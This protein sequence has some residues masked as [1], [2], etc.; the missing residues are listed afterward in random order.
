MGFA[1]TL[2]QHKGIF[3]LECQLLAKQ[4]ACVESKR[5]VNGNCRRSSSWRPTPLTPITHRLST[6]LRRHEAPEA[7][8]TLLGPREG[9]ADGSV[10]QLGLDTVDQPPQRDVDPARHLLP[11][12]VPDVVRG[13]GDDVVRQLDGLRNVQ[14]DGEEAHQR[15]HVLISD[16][17]AVFGVAECEG[18]LGFGFEDG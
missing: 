6:I 3:A 5:E 16:I 15:V 17:F 18:R 13:L 7:L 12:E 14:I 2:W 4:Q 11:L 1:Q 8:R 9:G 10:V